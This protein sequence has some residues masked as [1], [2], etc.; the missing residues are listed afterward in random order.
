MSE[1]WIK[2]SENSKSEYYVSSEGRCKRVI[3]ST[4]ETVIDSGYYNN[5][6]GYMQFAG[7]FVHRHV[8]KAFVPNPCNFEYVDHINSNR[9]DNRADNIR[10]VSRKANNS[11]DNSRQLRSKNHSAT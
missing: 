9:V 1:K 3:K 7:D 10:W 8:A 4:N 6:I 2:V 5:A 11:T